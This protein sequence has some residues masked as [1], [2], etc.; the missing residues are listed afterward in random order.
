MD[1]HRIMQINTLP[2]LVFPLAM[3]HLPDLNEGILA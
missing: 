3:P 2:T 1:N